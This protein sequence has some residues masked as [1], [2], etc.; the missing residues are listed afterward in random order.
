[1]LKKVKVNI[2]LWYLAFVI[3]MAIIYFALSRMDFE[4]MFTHYYNYYLVV[5][6]WIFS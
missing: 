6:H 5:L 4:G 3:V 2:G 1:M